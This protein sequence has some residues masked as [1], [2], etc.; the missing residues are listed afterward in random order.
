MKIVTLNVFGTMFLRWQC[1]PSASHWQPCTSVCLGIKK[2]ITYFYFNFF[3]I[4]VTS[5]KEIQ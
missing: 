4:M 1:V 5:V 2:K 3:K